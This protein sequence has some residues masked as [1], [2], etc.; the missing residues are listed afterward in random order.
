MN[1]IQIF[2]NGQFGEIRIV[3]DEN[4]EPLFCAKDIADALGYSDT[5][6]AI[7]RYC[8][9][10]KKVFHPHDNGVRG[11]N[12]LS[13]NLSTCYETGNDIWRKA[14]CDNREVFD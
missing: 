10:S 5:S 6:D 14:N 9:S 3:M 11:T 2:Q 4:N 12:I 7:Q 8:K 13:T 1:N